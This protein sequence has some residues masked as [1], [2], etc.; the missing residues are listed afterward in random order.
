[1]LKNKIFKLFSLS[2]LMSVA[3]LTGCS[4]STPPGGS[5]SGSSAS[6]PSTYQVSF[7][8]DGNLYGDKVTVTKGSTVTKP[9]DPT[10]AQD[11]DYTYTFKDWYLNGSSTPWNFDTDVVNSNIDLEKEDISD[12]NEINDVLEDDF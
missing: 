11:A 8:V 5:S 10:K 4:T 1:M 3:C 7:Y 6:T 2:L 12:N 9:Q